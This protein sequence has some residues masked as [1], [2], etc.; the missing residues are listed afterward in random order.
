MSDNFAEGWVYLFELA[1]VAIFV[2]VLIEPL[3]LHWILRKMS[4]QKLQLAILGLA[5]LPGY[6]LIMIMGG[7]PII[8]WSLLFIGPV[9]VLI[10]PFA[11]PEL[12]VPQY[13][14]KC[15]LSGYIAVI[16]FST[17]LFLG[18]YLSGGYAGWYA[19][20]TIY[21]LT[22][23]FSTAIYAGLVVL[24]TLVAFAVYRFMQGL[25]PAVHAKD[26]KPE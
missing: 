7:A 6:I 8:F 2:V 11:Y 10:P 14:F 19:I 23:I 20:P 25:Y 17:V 4:N 16:L 1:A 12:I 21:R 9:A 24:D 22:P 5:L 13:R 3:V 26:K 18:F 15:I